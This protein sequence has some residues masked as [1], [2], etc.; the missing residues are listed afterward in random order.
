MR[1]VK[2]Q[3]KVTRHYLSVA[4]KLVTD[5]IDSGNYTTLK[6][7]L[8]GL[9]GPLEEDALTTINDL[10]LY[11][12]SYTVKKIRKWIPAKRG[13]RIPIDSWV[14]ENVKDLQV[15]TSVNRKSDTIT[16]T[17]TTFFDTKIRQLTSAIDEDDGEDDDSLKESISSMVG[18]LFTVQNLALAGVAVIAVANMARSD[19][20][21]IADT[22]VQW[23]TMM[24]DNVCD[25]CEAMEGQT[26]KA[27]EEPDDIPLHANCRCTWDIVESE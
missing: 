17:Y 16:N 8:E 5:A 18:G 26:F 4:E 24:D 11:E 10:A 15:S 13:I 19:V 12:T 1:L 20:A 23:V 7:D 9:L 27:G 6:E 25:D 22:Y 2:T 3:A 14:L 21:E